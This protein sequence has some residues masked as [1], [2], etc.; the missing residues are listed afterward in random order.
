[1]LRIVVDSIPHM[2][3]GRIPRRCVLYA[4]LG[5]VFYKI[6]ITTPMFWTRLGK[7]VMINIPFVPVP[8]TFW[9][10]PWC[11]FRKRISNLIVQV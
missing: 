1:M 6:I 3:R 10:A 2:T 9:I 11:R 7:V 4:Y 5:G 8:H